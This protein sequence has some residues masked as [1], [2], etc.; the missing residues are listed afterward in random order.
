MVH[1]ISCKCIAW[2]FP[3][4]TSS[5]YIISE[6]QTADIRFFALCCSLI[7]YNLVSFLHFNLLQIK[8]KVVNLF[9][10]NLYLFDD[11]QVYWACSSLTAELMVLAEQSDFFS[12]ALS[13]L[14]LYLKST[15]LC[16][17]WCVLS[18]A[19][20]LNIPSYFFSHYQ[21]L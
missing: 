12:F 15:Y 20:C 11:Q 16:G 17:V 14:L 21:Y 19:V 4:N 5:L 7:L 1:Y 10:S 8:H 9:S 3:K 6:K 13:L 2:S 18:L